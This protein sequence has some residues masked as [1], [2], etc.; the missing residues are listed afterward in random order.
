MQDILDSWLKVQDAWLYLK[1]IFSSED[2][3]KQIPVE[4]KMFD[5]VDGHWKDIMHSTIL[6]THVLV[7]TSQSQLL[8]Q[9]QHSEVCC[10]CCIQQLIYILCT[11]NNDAKFCIFT[12]HVLVVN[13]PI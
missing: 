5:T 11:K 13:N 4:A 10:D 1:P 9:L 12:C 6:D 7:V 2:I 8:E 3:R